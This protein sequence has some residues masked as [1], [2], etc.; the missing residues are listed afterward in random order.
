MNTITWTLIIPGLILLMPSAVGAKES[1]TSQVILPEEQDY[2]ISPLSVAAEQGFALSLLSYNFTCGHTYSHLSVEVSRNDIYLSFLPTADPAAICPAI[3]MPYGPDFEVPGLEPGT[4]NVYA[5]ELVPCLVSEPACEIAVIPRL[6][7]MLTVEGAGSG[8]SISPTT[9]AA[10]QPLTLSL[11][12]SR[13]NCATEFSYLSVEAGDTAI[14][15]SFLAEENPFV[16]CAYIPGALFG[17]SYE[18]QGLR[19]GSYAVYA[20][21]LQPCMVEVPA[22][23]M[24]I[25][26]EKAG[27][28]TVGAGN[29][30]WFEPATVIEETSFRLSLYVTGDACASFSHPEYS[31][32]DNNIYLSF[33]EDPPPP[34]LAC[35]M[36]YVPNGPVFEIEGLT[37]GEY[38]VYATS[39]PGCVY[40]DPPCLMFYMPAPQYVG[41]LTAE[42][43]LNLQTAV[44]LSPEQVAENTSF[45]LELSSYGF[46]CNSVF[47]DKTVTVEENRLYLNYSYVETMM[48]CLEE[49]KAY[50]TEFAMPGLPPGQYQVHLAPATACSNDNPACGNGG[51]PVG[52]ITSGSTLPVLNLPSPTGAQ[53]SVRLKPDQLNI[54]LAGIQ[55]YHE[56]RVTLHSVRGERVL[57]V[58][59]NT[60]RNGLLRIPLETSLNRGVY[61]VTITENGNKVLSLP[62]LLE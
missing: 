41:L 25:I 28:L 53:P 62:A 22:C 40:D 14:Y 7:G 34:G 21:Q 48:V 12:S 35:T 4:Y 58:Y 2:I 27:Y 47:L 39:M 30:W 36:E 57:D 20:M 54:S 24:A 13:F 49:E 44:M 59:R 61:F 29:G 52:I 26:P 11:L 8:F 42:E 18:M 1:G 55:Q 51:E 3:Y 38:N 10:G 5:I 15:L 6:A 43:Y 32:N 46:T 31:I 60:P 17:P 50:S 45:T 33:V 37:S 16:D 23:R 9:A 56:V 19:E